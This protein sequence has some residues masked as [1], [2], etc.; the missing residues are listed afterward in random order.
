MRPPFALEGIDHVLLIVCGM[1]E[2]LQFYCDIPSRATGGRNRILP[3]RRDPRLPVILRRTCS[4]QSSRQ[5]LRIECVFV[6]QP[7]RNLLRVWACLLRF[8]AVEEPATRIGVKFV[9]SGVL[10]EVEISQ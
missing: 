10:E 2:A 4:V 9:E 3:T 1:R 5:A 7:R 8:I 6:T